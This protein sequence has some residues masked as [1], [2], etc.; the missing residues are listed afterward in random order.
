MVG[1]I[2]TSTL[3][4][5]GEIK[6]P[7]WTSATVGITATLSFIVSLLISWVRY[8]VTIAEETVQATAVIIFV[9]RLRFMRFLLPS[10]VWTSEQI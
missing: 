4:S 7:D 9:D 8:K 6:S 5:V 10:T 1:S 2:P 3:S